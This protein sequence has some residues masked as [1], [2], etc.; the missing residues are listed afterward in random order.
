M[1]VRR[2]GGR[3]SENHAAT[4]VLMLLSVTTRAGAVTVGEL[5]GGVV[6][7]CNGR[8]HSIDESPWRKCLSATRIGSGA[9]QSYAEIVGRRW[10]A[11]ASTAA[12]AAAG[13]S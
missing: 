3:S 7:A 2:L 6:V 11:A 4:A 8:S 9:L 12:A 5:G 10:L 13:E 1:A